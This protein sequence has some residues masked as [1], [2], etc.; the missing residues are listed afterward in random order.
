M[1]IG[2]ILIAVAF[3]GGGE[4]DEIVAGPDGAATTTVPRS[5]ALVGIAPGTTAPLAGGEIGVGQAPEVLGRRPLPGFGEVTATITGADGETCEVC[6]LS[7]ISD[8]QRRRG[9]MEVTDT[10]LGGYD[11]MLFE[12]PEEVDGAFWMRNTPMPLSIAYFDAVGS[13][14]SSADMTPCGD[15]EGCPT[16]PASGPLQYALEVVQGR[17]PEL[18]VAEGSTILITGR[19]CE[20]ATSGT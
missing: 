8:E 20:L 5:A 15:T 7:A 1:L 11:G 17:L 10:T 19:T 3:L 18:E 6:L 13:F 4:E 9:L 2:L 16:Y 12:F 14:V